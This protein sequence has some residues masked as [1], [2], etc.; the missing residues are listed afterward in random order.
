M[1]RSCWWNR[2]P[3]CA[4]K[5]LAYYHLRQS[6]LYSQDYSS[7]GCRG[8]ANGCEKRLKC[9][10]EEDADLGPL[11]WRRVSRVNPNG[12]AGRGLRGGW[13]RIRMKQVVLFVRFGT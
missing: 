6:I 13:I 5:L 4:P 10:G 7:N 11:G 1:F 8:G 3:G 12:P 9:A 2:S